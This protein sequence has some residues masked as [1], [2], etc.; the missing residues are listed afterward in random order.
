MKTKAVTILLVVF[1]AFGRRA[2]AQSCGG[3]YLKYHWAVGAANASVCSVVCDSVTTVFSDTYSCDTDRLV[4][5]GNN[6]EGPFCPCDSGGQIDLALRPDG[7]VVPGTDLCGASCQPSDSPS[8]GSCNA[9]GPAASSLLQPPLLNAGCQKDENNCSGGGADSDG[10]PVRFSSGRVESNP[11]TLF[12]V[13]APA[14]IFF[15]FRIQWGSHIKRL[16]ARTVL[17]VEVQPMI[18]TADEATYFIGSGWLDDFGDRLYVDIKRKADGVIVWQRRDGSVTFAQSNGWKSYGGR[19][20]LIDHCAIGC[21]GVTSDGY[22]RWD[23]RTTDPSNA[24]KIW[25]FEA[26][27]YSDY[28]SSALNYTLGRLKRHAVLAAGATDRIG[29]YGFTLS[30][31]ANSVLQS[32]QDTIGRRLEFSYHEV[33]SAGTVI[34]RSL[35]SVAYRPTAGGNLF[36]VVQLQLTKDSLLLD[37]VDRAAPTSSH[38]TRFRYTRFPNMGPLITQIIGPGTGA[39]ATPAEQA[40]TLP[41]EVILEENSYSP[42]YPF[43]GT[44]SYQGWD[45]II[46]TESRYPGRHYAYEYSGGTTQ[47]DLNQDS[48]VSCGSGCPSGT[49]CH[50]GRCYV[51]DVM[52]HAVG[53][54][55]P[56]QRAPADGVFGDPTGGLSGSI[57]SSYSFSRT[58]NGQGAPTE[59]FGAAGVR[60]T[61]GFDTIGR[62]RCIVRNDDDGEAFA[63]PE[64]PNTSACAGPATAQIVEVDYDGPCTDG[65]SRCTIKRTPSVLGGEVVEEEDLDANGFS[66][67]TK[68]SGKTH[69]IDGTIVV[70]TQVHARAYDEFGRL[71]VS[72]GPLD[73]SV[74]L[75][76]TETTY[77]ASDSARPLDAGQV[78]QVIRFV[79][80]SASSSTLITTYNGYDEFGVPH[81]VVAP[82]GDYVDYETSDR[83]TWTITQRAADGSSTHGSSMVRL[84]PDDSVRATADADGICVTFEYT[85]TT[86]QNPANRGFVGAPTAIRRGN[87]ADGKCGVLPIARNDGEVEVRTYMRAEEDRLESVQRFTDGVLEYRE[88]GFIYDRDRRLVSASTLDSSEPLG[89]SYTD[90]LRTGITAP[91]A[92]PEPRGQ[93]P[94]KVPSDTGWRTESGVDALARPTMLAH[95]ID[96]ANKQTFQF[97]YSSAMSPRP[98]LLLRGANGSVTSSSTFIYD[99]FGRLIESTVPEAGAPGNPHPTR[100]EYDLSNRMIRNRVGVGTPLVQTSV[101]TYDS[102]GRVLTVDRDIEHPVLCRGA[103]PIQDEEYHYD[104]CDAPDV[105]QGFACAHAKGRLTISRAIVECAPTLAGSNLLFTRGRW[106]DYDAA[107]R[108]SRVAYATVVTGGDPDPQVGTPAVMNYAFSPAGRLIGYS[109]PINGAFPTTYNLDEDSGRISDV[110]TSLLHSNNIATNIRYRAFGSL[111]TLTTRSLQPSSG[112]DRQLILRDTYRNDDVLTAR[113]WSFVDPAG[114]VPRVPVLAQTLSHTAAGMLANRIDANDHLASR[115]YKYDALLRMTC[116]ARGDVANDPSLQDCQ[117]PQTTTAWGV[118]PKDAQRTPA[119]LRLRP[120]ARAAGLFTYGNGVSATS[121]QDV[122]LTSVVQAEDR[123]YM[124]PSVEASIYASGSGQVQRVARSGGDLVVGYDALGRRLYDFD[125][126]DPVRSRRDYAYLP[127]G[128][129]GEVFGKTLDGEPTN[130]GMRYDERGRPLLLRVRVPGAKDDYELFW[131]DSNRLI[132]ANIIF[133][134][135]RF[136]GSPSGTLTSARWHYHYAGSTLVAATRELRGTASNV[137]GVKRFWVVADERGLPHQMVDDQGINYWQARWDAS[138]WRTVVGTPQ[139][140]MWVPFGLPGQIVLGETM[141]Y[142]RAQPAWG[143]EAVGGDSNATWKRPAIALNR[144]RAYDPLLGA[145]LQPDRADVLGRNDPEGYTYGRNAPADIADRTGQETTPRTIVAPVF[146]FPKATCGD[147]E[148][149]GLTSAVNRSLI[150]LTTCFK[151]ECGTADGENLVREWMNLLATSQWVCVEKTAD[152]SDV[153]ETL[154]EKTGTLIENGQPALGFN[155]AARTDEPIYLSPYA[156]GARP[157]GELR[158]FEGNCLASVVAHEVLH[159][160]IRTV[161]KGAISYL[162]HAQGIF[163]SNPVFSDT[164]KKRK[165]NEEGWVQRIVKECDICGNW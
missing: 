159:R 125:A 123:S 134:T 76:K 26:Q 61:R 107:G 133:Q 58:Y 1:A 84:N 66:I 45:G 3:T 119:G 127:N 141:I 55:L 128:Q 39:S 38:Y 121:P 126:R 68:T 41:G 64:L 124:S 85:D 21:D 36:P 31:D 151:G 18:H 53:T 157:G 57:G 24:T 15:G 130:V 118:L 103:K 69:D 143:T 106:Y 51:A 99:D 80:T 163:S 147:I 122:R 129:L 139:P 82:T 95:F 96:S 92:P 111:V 14:D 148:A 37:R 8:P 158:G 25:T 78:H 42:A 56:V 112:S 16:P 113:D 146:K 114:V 136:L 35:Q 164:P 6:L 150:K 110:G 142:G 117:L 70:Q 63:N 94:A 59:S 72:N 49:R 77:Y 5:S 28:G 44:G 115:V 67:R 12:Q 93:S 7:S 90:V 165:R 91:G 81:Q 105:P 33:K 4:N 71:T 104:S 40:Q 74:A 160:A 137:A 83:L 13:P 62:V 120:P 108:I 109:S 17:G 11:I 87:V 10:A 34:S 22:G 60:T 161:Q 43:G 144:W 100:F 140:E 32:V 79:G 88:A 20:Q 50:D 29:S 65:F 153:P 46:G 152:L 19:F 54:L 97:A 9:Q 2:D 149:V 86:H 47:F 73:D 162:E 30:W 135:P 131:D 156:F 138:G 52:E 23:V 154:D 145:F 98:T 75:D 48:G 27:A 101:T 132:A 116:E 102:L 89:F 155:D